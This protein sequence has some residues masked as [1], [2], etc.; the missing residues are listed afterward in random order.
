MPA[1]DTVRALIAAA[2]VAVL[3][4]LGL[5]HLYWAL[6][7]QGGATAAVPEVG[8]RA[9][10]KPSRAG[11]FLVAIALLASA[12]LVAIAGRLVP[13]LHGASFA[14]PLT[15]LIGAVFMAR[16]VGDFRLVGFFKRASASRFAR[17]DTLVYTPLC[18]LLG[19]AVLYLAY[20]DV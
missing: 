5:V 16:S 17:L 15:F 14:R 10:F 12:I 6:G 4:A 9:A 11:T 13:A 8:G 7:G 2:V 20:V 1:V 19:M 18:L 3:A